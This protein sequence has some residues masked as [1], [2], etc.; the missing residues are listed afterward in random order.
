MA[1]YVVDMPTQLTPEEI[2]SIFESFAQIEGFALTPYKGQNVYKKGMGF[3]A[4]PQ[5]LTYM[6]SP[7][8]LHIEAWLRYAVL[9]GVYVGEMG[10]DGF[11]GAVPKGILRDRVGKLITSVQVAEQQK[12]FAPVVNASVQPG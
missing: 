12:G 9:P 2:A 1:R 7:G 11:F 10:L 4:A 5:Y 3:I 8:M 6:A